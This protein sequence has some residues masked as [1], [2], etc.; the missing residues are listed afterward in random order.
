MHRL[1]ERVPEWCL[2]ANPIEVAEAL[3][4]GGDEP[5]A[6]APLLYGYTNYSRP[7]FRPHRL[8]Y[9]DIPAGP[10]G[11]AGSQLGGAGVAVSAR[12]AHVDEARA[13]AFWVASPEVQSGIYYDA[14]GQ[15]GYGA[16]WSDDR[17]NEDAWDFFRGTRRT[18]EEAWVR[19]RTAGFIEFQDTVSPWVTAT[20]SG[21]MTD[22]ELVRRAGELAGRLLV[23]EDA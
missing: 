10:R 1:T 15:P 7:G 14:G 13:Y 23:E 19:P 20:L 22:D 11:V 8:R 16:S 18:L 12:S 4:G 9:V 6:Y 21:E 3:A 2:A 17:L 5:W